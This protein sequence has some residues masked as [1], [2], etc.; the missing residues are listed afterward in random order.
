MSSLLHPFGGTLRAVLLDVD[1]ILIGSSDSRGQ[2]C[3]SENCL[4][5]DRPRARAPSWNCSSPRVWT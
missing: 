4:R 3:F 5:C 1:G 2:S